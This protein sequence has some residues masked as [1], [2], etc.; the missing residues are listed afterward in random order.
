MNNNEIAGSMKFWFRRPWSI[1]S[2]LAFPLSVSL[3]SSRLHC[4]CF[5]VSILN[6]Y[7]CLT[8]HSSYTKQPSKLLKST[9]VA[10]QQCR[11]R[12]YCTHDKCRCTDLY[13][14][15]TDAENIKEPAGRSLYNYYV[16]SAGPRAHV[17]TVGE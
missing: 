8:T 15:Q 11:W 7:L 4:L 12:N 16:I 17:E 14:A 9:K 5:S 3:T 10:W 2:M 13:T 1:S 6:S